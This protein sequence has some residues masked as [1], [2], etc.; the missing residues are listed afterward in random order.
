M[1]KQIKIPVKAKS[2]ARAKAKKP[3][4]KKEVVK[5]INPV[6]CPPHYKTQKQLQDKIDEYFK[7]V[8]GEFK[9]VAKRDEEGNL[10]TERICIRE[11]ES[12][13]ITGL[14]LFLGFDSRQ[15]V[16][17]YEKKGEFSYTIKRARLTVENAYEKALLSRNSTGA[18]FALKNF[19]WTD[20]QEIDH[21]TNG[22]S[23]V[24]TPIQFTKGK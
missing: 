22:Q 1:A 19:G 3:I 11:P 15:S 2:K 20:K 5:K 10:Y 8:N 6:G 13:S 17:D 24:P 9:D 12:H 14:A 21:T 23:L 18:I 4:V 16:Y 7:Y